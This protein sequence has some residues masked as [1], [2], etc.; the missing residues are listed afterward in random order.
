LTAGASENL[1]DE[2][3]TQPKEDDRPLHTRLLSAYIAKVAPGLVSLTVSRNATQLV[4]RRSYGGSIVV[5]NHYC[6]DDATYPGVGWRMNPSEKYADQIGMSGC[7]C[8]VCPKQ[9]GRAFDNERQHC[10]GKEHRE[11]AARVV[12]DLMTRLNRGILNG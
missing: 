9:A 4:L 10:R 5:A 2:K 6:Q 11:N 1:R 8:L 12:R 7:E 3:R